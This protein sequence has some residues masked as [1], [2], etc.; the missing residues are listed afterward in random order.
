MLPQSPANNLILRIAHSP[1]PVRVTGNI[2]VWKV[3][4]NIYQMFADMIPRHSN[5]YLELAE[6][7]ARILQELKDIVHMKF[8]GY[9]AINVGDYNAQEAK[10]IHPLMEWGMYVQLAQGTYI[11]G[12]MELGDIVKQI[13]NG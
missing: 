11:D 2:W 6:T 10:Q 4:R 3:P 1:L 5:A 13:T 8:P 9:V 7:K 12:T